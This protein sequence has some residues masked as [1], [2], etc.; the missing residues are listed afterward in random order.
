M[1]YHRHNS[2]KE[3]LENLWKTAAPSEQVTIRNSQPANW[4]TDQ[5]VWKKQK[6]LEPRFPN[7]R[8]ARFI[9]LTIDPAQ[10]SDAQEGYETGKRHLRE[11][12]YRLDKYLGNGERTPYC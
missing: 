2:E 10:Y 8:N 3:L 9:T 5:G 11:F 12:L 7:I 4:V 6:E 1:V